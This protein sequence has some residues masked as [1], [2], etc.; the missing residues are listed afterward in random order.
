MRIVNFWADGAGTYTPPGHWNKIACDLIVK[1]K[2][3]QLRAARALAL[4][5]MSIEDAGICCW[6][7]KTL[8][9]YPRPSQMG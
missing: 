5:N 3:N 7:V 1:Y 4:T 9:F 2:F 8:Y 6:D